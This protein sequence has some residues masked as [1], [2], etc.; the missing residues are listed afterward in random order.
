MSMNIGRN[1]DA[2]KSTPGGQMI[3]AT[4]RSEMIN[5][6]PGGQ[7]INAKNNGYVPAA[8]FSPGKHQTIIPPTRTNAA[9]YKEVAELST[10]EI[11]EWFREWI[12]D[13]SESSE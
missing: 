11:Y 6:T 12:D 9:I 13:D 1:Y 3:N 4:F 7:M 5:A 2:N 8:K 10:E